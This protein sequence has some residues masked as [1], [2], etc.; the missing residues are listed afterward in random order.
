MPKFVLDISEDYD[1]DLFGISCRTKNYRICWE[2]NN[3]LGIDLKRA[4]DFIIDKKLVT[5]SFAFY[6]FFDN[7]NHISYHLIANKSKNGNLLPEKKNIDFIFLIKGVINKDYTLKIQHK[8]NTISV[9]LTSF[10]VNPNELKSKQ[11]LLF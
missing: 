11:N 5:G 4:D 2:L 9:I 10:P 3:A 7:E 6:E 1:F 8:I